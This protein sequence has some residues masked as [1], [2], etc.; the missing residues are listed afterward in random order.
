MLAVHL[1]KGCHCFSQVTHC[2]RM[3]LVAPNQADGART[4]GLA[5]VVARPHNLSRRVGQ[6]Q[7]QGSTTLPP[8]A[9]RASKFQGFLVQF[10]VLLA[11]PK[12][13]AKRL[14]VSAKIHV[15]VATNGGFDAVE[16]H[17]GLMTAIE[18]KNGC[19]IFFLKRWCLC[20]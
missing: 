7:C 12:E 5:R 19:V 10:L 1:P 15:A 20:S 14:K 4:E 3:D 16:V 11:T 18:K 6:G 9:E 13:I 17:R 8:L 2:F